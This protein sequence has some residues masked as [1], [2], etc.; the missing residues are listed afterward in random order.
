MGQEL[1]VGCVQCAQDR[2]TR[3]PA[4]QAAF[5]ERAFEEAERTALGLTILS[6]PAGPG[7]GSA[8]ALDG[9]SRDFENFRLR[10]LPAG[11][12]LGSAQAFVETDHGSLLYTGDFKLRQGASAETTAHCPAETL[13]METTYGLP[14]YVFPPFEEVM[15]HILKFCIETLEENSVPVLLGYSLGKAQ[16]I[17]ASL[18]GAGLPVML[19]GTISKLVPIYLEEGIA[20]P[21]F[22]EWDPAKSSGHVLICPPTTAGSR[23]MAAV[24]F[25]SAALPRG[26]MMR[27]VW[28]TSLPSP[29]SDSP[30]RTRSTTA[31]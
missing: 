31:I 17:L 7:L 8:T 25:A 23:A 20:F 27:S 12:V 22:T 5:F 1:G 21:E 11:H 26:P 3:R 6:M 28:A 19:H 9:E 13:V 2:G 30:T 10:L 16:E 4:D 15:A 24:S 29:T 18:C 14:R